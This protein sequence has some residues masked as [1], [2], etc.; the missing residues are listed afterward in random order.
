MPE[1]VTKLKPLGLNKDVSLYEAPVDKWTDG[2]NVRFDNNSTSKIEGLRQV[3][4]TPSGAPYWLLRF[5]AITEDYW[6]YPSLTNIYRVYTSGTTT[7][8]EDV[9]R[10]SGGNYSATASGGW[11]GGV[12]GGVVVLNNGVDE[13]Q[14]MGTSASNFSA[15]SNWGSGETAKV[16]RPFKRFLVALDKTEAGTRYPFRVHWSHPAEGGT[17]PTSWDASDATKDTG[18]V[19]LSQ[20]NGFVVDALPLGDANIVYKTD[21]VWSMSYEGGQSIFGFRQLFSDAGILGRDC[22]KSF[23]K[24]H[25]VVSDDDVYIHDGNSKQSVVDGQIRDDLFNSIHPDYKERTFVAVDRESNEMLVCFVSNNN[26]S[27]AFADTAFVWNWR[28]NT[29][30]KRDLPHV[31]YIAWDV[32]DTVSTTDWTESGDW[33]T[34][35]DSWNSPPKSNLLIADALNSK[36][37][38]PGGRQFDGVDF[39]SWIEKTGM[40]LDYTGS[41]SVSKLVPSAE[42]SGS[43]DFYIGVQQ[44]AQGGIT[45]KGPY[46]YTPG[47]NTEI[48]VRATGVYLGVRVESTSDKD[49]KLNSFD[50]HWTPQGKR[51]TAV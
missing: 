37:L 28:N 36:L 47:V 43:I 27:D 5:N 22:V 14:M 12:L 33:D 35:V 8:H 13:P 40:N 1:Q 24:Q 21:S 26:A 46:T 18:Y 30:S 3:Y 38:V 7:T 45:W 48:P 50:L 41:K 25:F 15:L 39:R 51:G 34:D 6:I 16:I 2:S 20:T 19:D 49:W 32:V 31:S 10:A 11:N 9:T 4:G 42:G 29:W 23:D 17:V 44:A